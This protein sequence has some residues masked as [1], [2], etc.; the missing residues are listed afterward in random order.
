MLCTAHERWLTLLTT[1]VLIYV[2]YI[3]LLPPQPSQPFTF[4]QVQ[5]PTTQSICCT[6][7]THTT[8]IALDE[9]VHLLSNAWAI[10]VRF[11]LR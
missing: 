11:A 2:D 9:P 1:Y 4:I 10:H 3:A 6:E 7:P 5:Q 8:N